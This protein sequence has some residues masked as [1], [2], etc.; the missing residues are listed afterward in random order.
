MTNGETKRDKNE[1]TWVNRRWLVGTGHEGIARV[2][3]DETE[4]DV[5]DHA[6][7]NRPIHY[8]ETLMS[9]A[10]ASQ[11]TDGHA[12]GTLGRYTNQDN[13]EYFTGNVTGG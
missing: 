7:D 11:Q 6:Q 3:H 13:G 9:G 8:D 10:R 5:T 2:F 12:V 1:I 4:S